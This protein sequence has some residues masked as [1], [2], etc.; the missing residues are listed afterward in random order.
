MN[1]IILPSWRQF[2]CKA[3]GRLISDCRP[4]IYLQPGQANTLLPTIEYIESCAVCAQEKG[5]KTKQ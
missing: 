3:C 4:A 5:S 2:W 1:S